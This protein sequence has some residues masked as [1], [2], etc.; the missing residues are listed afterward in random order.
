MIMYK[1]II[2][3]RKVIDS[4]LTFC[5]LHHPNEAILILCGDNKKDMIR[6]NKLMVPPLSEYGPYYSG[7][8][9]YMLPYDRSII[10]T[11]HSHPNGNYTPS[12]QDLHH[13]IGL[14]GVI[15]RHPYEDNDIFVYNSR[16]DI[17]EYRIE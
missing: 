9:T 11:A 8:P 15:V 6:V 7:F 1:E 14:I 16:G 13:F 3:K 4:I 12:L 10:G 2:F 5:K 17:L